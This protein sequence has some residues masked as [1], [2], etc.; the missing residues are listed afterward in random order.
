VRLFLLFLRFVL[1]R[2]HGGGIVVVME[3]LIK[4]R[5]AAELLAVSP[6]NL[7]AFVRE[8]MPYYDLGKSRR[9]RASEILQWV[10]A[11]KVA[12]VTMESEAGASVPG[13][14]GH[15]HDTSPVAPCATVEE[16]N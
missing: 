12:P 13:E 10:E 4:A 2:R 6:P 1:T 9:Y 16:K 3:R 11:K 7:L 14:E 15:A 5:E 8:G